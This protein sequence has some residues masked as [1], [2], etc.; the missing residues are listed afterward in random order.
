MEAI[1]KTSP[2]LLGNIRYC[3]LPHPKAKIPSHKA[4]QL[5]KLHQKLVPVTVVRWAKGSLDDHDLE[6][7]CERF[8]SKDDVWS[9]DFLS[10]KLIPAM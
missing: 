6:S 5:G 4:T 1:E 7:I 3:L 10:G 9:H 2:F 8:S